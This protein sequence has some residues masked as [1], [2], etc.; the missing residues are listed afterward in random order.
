MDHRH[1]TFDNGRGS[2]L[3][4]RLEL[5]AGEPRAWALFAHCFTC[6]KDSAAATRISRALC[7]RGFAVLRFDFTGLG[8]SSGEFANESFSSNL[9]DLVAAADYLRGEFAAPSLLIG[10]SLGGAAVLAVAADIPEVRAVVTV[11][12]PSDPSHV[13]HLLGDDLAR[14]E[15][16]GEAEVK[17][18]GRAFR[19]GRKFI[20]D[21]AE[22][23]QLERIRKLHR[24]LLILHSPRDEVV[25]ID[26]ARR[27]YQAAVHPK[28]YI[29]LDDADHL[30][31]RRE[32]AIYVADLIASWSSRYLP[33]ETPEETQAGHEGVV[34]VVEQ[35][36]SYTQEIQAGGHSLTADEPL[37][38]GGADLGPSPYD[39]LLSALGAC[40]SM[41]LRM[42]ANHKGWPLEGVSVELTHTK[43]HAEDCDSCEEKQGR[44]DRI[45]RRIHVDGDLSED[46]RQ[47]LLEI[48]NRCPVHRTLVG[49]KEI[50]SRLV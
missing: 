22:S 6:G 5:P 26:H 17:I 2:A 24:A 3:A 7:R 31:T 4:A 15:R 30:L 28:S 21:L 12:A 47:R 48:A 8:S 16:D 40:T 41:T 42:Y 20:D 18:A 49:E 1:L 45:E 11:G 14:I 39:L 43:I 13:A 29:S 35:A 9:E 46:Q 32:D 19:I 36:G 10:H 37:S 27:I 50:L 23:K 25:D 33:E 44:V 34:R 38:L